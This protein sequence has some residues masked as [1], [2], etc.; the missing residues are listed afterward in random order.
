MYAH[1][2]TGFVVDKNME[3]IAEQTLLTIY[4]VTHTRQKQVQQIMNNMISYHME[5]TVLSTVSDMSPEHAV[6][7]QQQ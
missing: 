3:N 4:T 2:W 7:K 5:Q 6:A 1:A